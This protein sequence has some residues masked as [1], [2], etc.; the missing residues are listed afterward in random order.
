VIGVELSAELATI[1]RVNA[2]SIA[3]RFPERPR[4]TITEGNVID[5]SLPDGK[6]VFFL[7][8]SFGERLVAQMVKKIEAALKSNTAHVFFV[9]YNP[10]H[11]GPLDASPAFTRYYAEKI[12]YNKSEL[13]F[14]PDTDDTVVIWQSVRGWTPTPHQHI[15]RKIIITKALWRAELAR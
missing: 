10:V 8:H 5:F 12:P 3:Q 7:Y 11:A 4:I 13:G 6:L 9:Y 1:A 2:A 15:D 14:G